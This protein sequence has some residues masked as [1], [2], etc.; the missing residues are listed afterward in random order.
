ML[1]FILCALST[2]INPKDIQ[3]SEANLT[4]LNEI[5][6]RG[7]HYCH[8]HQHNCKHS[9]MERPRTSHFFTEFSWPYRVRKSQIDTTTTPLSRGSTSDYLEKG[10]SSVLTESELPKRHNTFRPSGEGSLD[11]RE[12]SVN[13][14]SSMAGNMGESRSLRR[15]A[16][17]LR[18][19]SFLKTIFQKT[20]DDGHSG[21]EQETASTEKSGVLSRIR[22]AASMSQGRNRRPSTSASS[23]QHD[24]DSHV[25]RYATTIPQIGTEAPMTS[26]IPHGGAA[27]RAAAAAQ[28]ERFGSAR[29]LAL[30][31]GLRA[32]ER[33]ISNDS[34][35]GI[36]IDLR[37]RTD[38]LV[39]LELPLARMGKT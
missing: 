30:P 38:E 23:A 12:H 25:I 6:L 37:D 28:N 29:S 34:E 17:T 5:F 14:R 16:S 19:K 32:A 9:H 4:K 24:C 10:S 8:P 20:K 1:T 15:R 11:T 7:Q 36:G 31:D 33:K 35:S 13:E 39:D 2:I 21:Q 27:A 26:H 3:K 22:R 18:R